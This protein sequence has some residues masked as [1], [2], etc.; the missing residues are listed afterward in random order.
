[1]TTILQPTNRELGVQMLRAIAA[2][3][4]LLHHTIQ[5]CCITRDVPFMPHIWINYGF[6]GVNI[7]FVISGYVMTL[8]LYQGKQFFLQR[9]AR[10]Y[11]AFWLTVAFS[12]F[13]SFLLLN[14]N[15]FPGVPWYFDIK[16]ALLLPTKEINP[17]YQI[18]YW[19][20]VYEMTFYFIM[21]IVAFSRLSS[22]RLERGLW[23]WAGIITIVCLSHIYPPF[24]R[25]SGTADV[26]LWTFLSP[27][28]FLFIAGA[29][30]GIR[31][32]SIFR[33]QKWY[34]LAIASVFFWCLG[35]LLH[36]PNCLHLALHAISYLCLLDLV[37]RVK[38]PGRLLVMMGNASYGLY[39]IHILLILAFIKVMPAFMHTLSLFHFGVI[40]FIVVLFGGVAFGA[41]EYNIHAKF[42]KPLLAYQ[43]NKIRA[44]QSRD[45]E[46]ATAEL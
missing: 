36:D 7:F 34:V 17:T 13:L 4:V 1:M 23:I 22:K 3:F 21:S 16:S 12:A 27:T 6:I 39:L 15:S 5:I 9:T 41:L 40:T 44:Q 10:I 43:K 37:R 28:N 32:K 45:R 8:C 29:L 33:K 31:G 42:I 30:Y 35:K 11:P 38:N 24:N 26:G 2:I 18:P 14:G 20:L 25:E 46:G 19:T